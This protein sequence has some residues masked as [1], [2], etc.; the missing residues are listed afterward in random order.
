MMMFEKNMEKLT[1]DEIENSR[2][3]ELSAKIV[4]NTIIDN[5]YNLWF[6]CNDDGSS[7]FHVGLTNTNEGGV[8]GWS[9]L[10]LCLRYVNRRVVKK[11]LL[12]A[13]GSSL[14]LSK[15]SLFHLRNMLNP[16]NAGVLGTIIVNP[17]E[18]NFFVPI[19]LTYFPATGKSKEEDL[20]LDLDIDDNEYVNVEYNKE[21]KEY[22][23]TDNSD[24]LH[25]IES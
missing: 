22:E 20:E 25:L 9:S 19:P 18:D 3:G 2:R 12:K 15:M 7:I 6:I 21:T 16:F 10:Q 4:Y 5:N 23:T 14:I 11:V 17:C 8:I 13:F 1:T 24:Y